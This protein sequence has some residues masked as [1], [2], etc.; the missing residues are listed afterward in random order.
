MSSSRV[1]SLERFP[2]ERIAVLTLERSPL[3]AIDEQVVTE[4]AEATAELVADSETRAVLVRSA[5]EGVFMAGADIREF[6]RIGEE[7]M[8]RAL[9]A[10]EVFACFAEVPQPTIAA[11]NGHALGGGLELALACD[12][13]FAARVEGALIGLPE[14]RL[15]LLP[16][17]GGTQR[18]T[19]I[20]GPARATELI[21]KGIQLSP[22][23]AAED[24][25]VHFL[26]E[27][28]ELEA[29]ARDYAVRLARQAPIALRGIKRAIRAAR[30]PD[31][32]AVE[33]EAF[34]EVLGSADA[35]TGVRAFLEGE[36][37][38]FSGE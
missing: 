1:V 17:A 23:Q 4:L 22:E 32:P 26:V 2:D 8:E 31:G 33:A 9:L 15:G 21:M 18:L 36:R 29:K 14:V 37:P 25:I 16:G 19:W 30:S 35:Q 5:L 7:G 12:F 24:G 27:P 11:I 3:N 6:E 38:T 20:V 10:Q 28:E 13:R 34:R